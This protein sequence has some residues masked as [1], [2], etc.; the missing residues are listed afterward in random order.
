MP[1]PSSS[2]E[3]PPLPPGSALKFS[4]AADPLDKRFPS[5]LQNLEGE[6]ARLL[7][8]ASSAD[9]TQRRRARV[10]PAA[11]AD[12]THTAEV[13]R[14]EVRDFLKDKAD[15]HQRRAKRREI[16]ESTAVRLPREVA[17]GQLRRGGKHRE[18]SYLSDGTA[19]AVSRDAQSVPASVIPDAFRIIMESPLPTRE[20]HF[21]TIFGDGE[22]NWQY[23][24]RTRQFEAMLFPSKVPAGRR[25]VLLLHAWIND[26]IGR[27]KQSSTAL[28]VR[29][30][31]RAAPAPAQAAAPQTSQ[32]C[33]PLRKRATL[34]L[35]RDPRADRP[36]CARWRAT[37]ALPP[38]A[39][40]FVGAGGG[41]AA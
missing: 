9:E 10:N 16:A 35:A 18:V 20:P 21:Y 15:V 7:E 25:D 22:D 1:G 32:R 13:R 23:N 27:L 31:V 34:A 14:E 3:L 28:Q 29:V 5:L 37:H 8:W 11:P 39:R 2:F 19:G 12:A 26:M 40:V 36:P 17:V 38:S 4:S 33:A 6:M 24:E 30:C 41:D